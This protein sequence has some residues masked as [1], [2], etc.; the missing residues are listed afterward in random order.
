MDPATAALISSGIGAAGGLLAGDGGDK[1][2]SMKDLY[3][4]T[5]KPDIANLRQ[6][7]LGMDPAEFYPGRTFAHMDPAQTR[8]YLSM[9]NYG[10]PGGFGYLTRQNQLGQ[11]MAGLT[12]LAGG[13]GFVGDLASM[14]GPQFGY[15]QGTF[16]TTLQ[17]LMP[18]LQGSYDEAT[19]DIFR[20]LTEGTLPGLD[21]AAAMS[22]NTA[23]TRAGVAEGIATRGAQDRAADIGSQL[24][25]NALNQA[26]R[27]AMLGGQ[28]NLGADLRTQGNILQGF[29]SLAN[30]G[31]PGLSNALTTDINNL[32]MQIAGGGAFQDMAQKR[33]NE[34]IA[35]WEFEQ[36]A[37]WDLWSNQLN[38]INATTPAGM[39]IN[40]QQTPSP[41][42]LQMALQGGMAGMGMYDF[43]N[44]NFG[45]GGAS[46]PSFMPQ[47]TLGG[48]YSGILSSSDPF[49]NAG[50]GTLGG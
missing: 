24:T 35:R 37:P 25:Q 50:F 17:N 12:N 2:M 41:S 40:P 45:G 44:R 27:A 16:D 20:N 31:L 38:L 33:I 43:Y 29:Q 10:Q 49:A 48:N 34:D 22:G 42:A 47:P 19:R 9:V 46:T 3:G 5:L 26:Q 18:G 30:V 1:F 13:T 15:D 4:K 32:Q 21:M 39:G 28:Q 23:S 14:G 36:Q 7:V 6:D 8:G 11:G